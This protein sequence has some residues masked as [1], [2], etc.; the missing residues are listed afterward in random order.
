MPRASFSAE[1]Q[2]ELLDTW[3]FDDVDVLVNFAFRQQDARVLKYIE[4]VFE[5][6]DA[7]LEASWKTELVN[8]RVEVECVTAKA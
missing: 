6:L 4:R 2:C 3:Y 7:A 1:L 5:L 8:K